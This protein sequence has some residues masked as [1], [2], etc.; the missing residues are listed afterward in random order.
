[1]VDHP[2]AERWHHEP[3]RNDQQSDRTAVLGGRLERCGVFVGPDDVL[4][5]VPQQNKAG[6]CRADREEH[7]SLYRR[8]VADGL[9][10]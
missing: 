9:D 7:L 4:D 1:M 2:H 10:G 3:D 5:Q 8:Q 6:E